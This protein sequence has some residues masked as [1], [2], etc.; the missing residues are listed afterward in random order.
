MN[1]NLDFTIETSNE[2]A[3][4]ISRHDL[5]KLT[6]KEI[7]LC[8]NYILYGK[9][10]DKD[11]T[12]A[13]DRKEVQIKTKFRSY[14]KKEPI[15][16]DSLLES[17]TFNENLLTTKP[18]VY[19]KVKPTIDKEK[20]KD[21]LGMRELWKE[22]EK[23]QRLVDMTTGKE[24]PDEGFIPLTQKQ[25]YYAK[26]TLIEL[27][28][29]QYY[30][31]DSAFP[32][33]PPPQNKGQWF[34]NVVDMQMNYPVFPRGL[35]RVENDKDFKTPCMDRNYGAAAQNIDN[36]IER[37]EKL[38]RPYF[39][40]LDKRH[41]YNLILHYWDIKT[42]IADVPDSLLHNLLW[43]L[44]FYIDKANLTEQQLLIV[45]DKKA[46]YLNKEIAEHLMDEMGI[47]H[48]ENY[49]STVW[50][51]IAGLIVDAAALNYDEWLCKDYDKAWKKCNTCGEELLRDP[52]NFVR[53]AKSSD[54]LT[55]RCKR[56]DKAARQKK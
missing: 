49:I 10:P 14:S 16:L 52:R 56:C 45:R 29:H 7:E 36:E 4:F 51:K 11:Y 20:V 1:F 43:T 44:D 21:I 26:H 25:L 46:K 41:V 6:K 27:R 39:N 12:S 48:Q 18:T 38:N 28:T 19:K 24:Q 35:M 31:M 17:P 50:N 34:D 3:D 2:R 54:G 40:F 5:S 53:K 22:I 23:L 30:L 47:Y 32:T 13:V 37:L 8:A 15:S 42:A 9:D 55:H 33:L